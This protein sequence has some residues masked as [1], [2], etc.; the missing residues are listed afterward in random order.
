VT[1]RVSRPLPLDILR[2]FLRNNSYVR[3]SSD[4]TRIVVVKIETL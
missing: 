3:I 1:S 4:P 2:P